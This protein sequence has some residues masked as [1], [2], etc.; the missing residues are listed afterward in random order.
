MPDDRYTVW[1]CLEALPGG[2]PPEQRL[3]RALK[4]LLKGYGFRC[5]EVRTDP[6]EPEKEAGRG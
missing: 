4:A 3:K 6:P 2:V 5:R 1:I